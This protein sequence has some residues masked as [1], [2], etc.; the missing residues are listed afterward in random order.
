MIPR[1]WG[2]SRSPLFPIK[3][4]IAWI[5]SKSAKK[6]ES[7]RI[8]PI[9]EEQINCT[10]NEIDIRQE[11]DNAMNG[12]E[13]FVLKCV[14]LTKQYEK[15]GKTALDNFFLALPEREC[16]G[17]LGPNGAGKTTLISIL[18]GT[19]PAS[20]GYA[21][22]DGE[23]TKGDNQTSRNVIGICPQFD[24]L[25]DDL[26]VVEHLRYY[27]KM[28]GIPRGQK[29]HVLVSNL[30]DHV[31]LQ[32][33][34]NKRA[35]DLSGG[36]KRKLS[37]AISLCGNPKLLLLDEPT[38]GLDPEARRDIWDII[39]DAREGRSTIITTHNMEEAD[40][41]CT[42]IGI[43]ANGTMKCI[44]NQQHLKSK[45]G[46]GYSLTITARTFAHLAEI[47][48][49]V[50][51]LYPHATLDS[52]YGTNLNYLIAAEQMNIS[53]L[54]NRMRLYK[55]TYGIQEWGINQTSLEEVFLKIVRATEGGEACQEV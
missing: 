16:F 7:T 10:S 33:H 27:F 23:T 24:I 44:G 12:R 55:D 30:T 32:D 5:K 18:S 51:S 11:A 29:L 43:M 26:T 21:V 9:V 49:W 36:M 4:T 46:A 6:G 13:N 19:I 40:V 22:I 14:G 53:D 35:R 38:T 42:R 25:W 39:Q 41:L 34:L 54:F 50:K 20:S 15:K 45:Y 48:R 2:I 17:L 52:N 3:D 31:G 1:S 37:I 47:Q 28:K 8:M